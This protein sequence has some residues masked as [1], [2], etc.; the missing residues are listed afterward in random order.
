MPLH[1]PKHTK[2]D[3]TQKQDLANKHLTGS[4]VL[5]I[6]GSIVGLAIL[7]NILFALSSQN[8]QQIEATGTAPVSTVPATTEPEQILDDD[9]AKPIDPAKPTDIATPPA[10]STPERRFVETIAANTDGLLAIDMMQSVIA[11]TIFDDRRKLWIA[12][13]GLPISEAEYLMKE[14]L[15][16]A[17][18]QLDQTW[19]DKMLVN[20]ASGMVKGLHRWNI[21]N[22]EDFEGDQPASSPSDAQS[23]APQ[24]LQSLATLTSQDAGS[25]INIRVAP[26]P[27][28][29]AQHFGYAGDEISLLT[30]ARGDDGYIWYK[31][32]FSSSAAEGWVRGDFVQAS[33]AP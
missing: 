29:V 23:V 21:E 13:N 18:Y 33:L 25:K 26:S 14:A 17:S 22:P 16:Q 15:R 9:P 28:A 12:I 31:V 1:T 3:A 6:L 2:S 5:K 8:R 7:V 24:T 19:D 32:R 11:P 27:N 20:L 10:L 4:E 30:E